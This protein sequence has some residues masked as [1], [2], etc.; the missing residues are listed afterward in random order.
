MAPP[1]MVKDFS[2][3]GIDT[4]Q[5]SFSS[6]NLIFYFDSETNS[7]PPEMQ[8]KLEKATL[9]WTQ[10]R[11]IKW[12]KQ[13]DVEDHLASICG[14]VDPKQYP[15]MPYYLYFGFA[16]DEG[17]FSLH[18]RFRSLDAL[19]D[20]ELLLKSMKLKTSKNG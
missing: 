15:E 11:K 10:E 20:I 17:N 4:I 18:F 5:E 12:D 16:V 3:H 1:D 9:A 13:I 6:P 19:N 7:L 14:I 2:G 8:S